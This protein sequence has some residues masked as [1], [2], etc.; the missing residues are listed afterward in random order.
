MGFYDKH[1]L[2]HFIN[3]ACGTKPIMHQR[4]KVVPMARGTV[5][6]IGIVYLRETTVPWTGVAEMTRLS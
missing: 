6:E 5:L 3:C 2:P 4:Q 1:I